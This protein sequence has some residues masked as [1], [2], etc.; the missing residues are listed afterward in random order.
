MAQVGES[1]QASTHMHTGTAVYVRV[2]AC[3]LVQQEGSEV[4]EGASGQDIMMRI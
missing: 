4:G 2:C 3:A 1:E